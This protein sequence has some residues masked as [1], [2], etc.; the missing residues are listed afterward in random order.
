MPNRK[1]DEITEKEE[2]KIYKNLLINLHEA[3]WTGNAKKFSKIMNAIGD[4]SFARTNSNPGN[5]EQ[6]EKNRLKTLL[7]LEKL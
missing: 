3:R 4:Y 7:K 2:L 6:E 1:L 5:E